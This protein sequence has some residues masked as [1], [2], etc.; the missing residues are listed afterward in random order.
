MT[1]PIKD[2]DKDIQIPESQLPPEMIAYRRLEN[3]GIRV[4]GEA[5]YKGGM[6]FTAMLDAVKVICNHLGTTPEQ[7]QAD[8]QLKLF[9]LYKDMDSFDDMWRPLIRQEQEKVLL[10]QQQ[11]QKRYGKALTELRN[12][13]A[14]A[15]RLA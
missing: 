5:S 15:T 1:E 4:G 9:R 12:S 8:M 7:F 6:N 10:S 14:E 13:S 11:E 3:L 2:K